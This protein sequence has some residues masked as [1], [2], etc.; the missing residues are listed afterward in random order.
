MT[1]SQELLCVTY[2]TLPSSLSAPSMEKKCQKNQRP[3]AESSSRAAP[4]FPSTVN[5][6]ILPCS[7]TAEEQIDC[8]L[9][10]ELA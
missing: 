2:P 7:V 9:Y 3:E 10:R 4:P 5:T 1:Q 8:H 6:A